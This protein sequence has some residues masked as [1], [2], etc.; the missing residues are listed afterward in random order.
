MESI[1]ETECEKQALDFKV[2][3]AIVQVESS[4]NP[5]V[6][7]Y[8]RGFFHLMGTTKYAARNQI[9]AETETVLQQMSWGLGQVMG[10]T[11]RFLGYEGPLTGLVDPQ[12]N[13]HLTCLYFAKNCKRRYDKLE[14]QIAAYNAGSVIYN[15]KGQL[16]NQKYVDKVLK[17]LRTK[18]ETKI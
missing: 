18:V 14:E 4:W 8:E 5:W 10:G 9:N 12:M 15:Q 17:E 2:M 16:H 3:K 7:R 1:L 11:A 13:L 6:T